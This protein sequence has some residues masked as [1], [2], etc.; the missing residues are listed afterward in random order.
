MYKNLKIK[1]N[2]FD[3]QL[4]IYFALAFLLTFLY[5]YFLINTG[6]V[7]DDAY[8]SQIK[9][10]ILNEGVTILEKYYTTT[11]AWILGAGRAWVFHFYF[12][13]LYYFTQSEVLIKVI[14]LIVISL[15]IFYLGLLFRNL[16]GSFKVGLLA[17][18]TTPIFFQLRMWHDPILAFTFL[19]PLIFLYLIVSF[20]L[21]QKYLDENKTKYLFWSSG[22]H[23]IGLL[24]Y[25]AGYLF[26]I[27]FII[28]ALLKEKNIFKALKISALPVA[29]S[30]LIILISILLKSKINPVFSS[31]YPGAELNLNL[32]A[33][34]NASAIQFVSG[35][36]L[37]YILF[38]KFATLKEIF[39]N[40]LILA[41]GFSGIIFSYV[42]I[43]LKENVN[44]KVFIYIGSPLIIL[45]AILM[46]ISG[47]QKELTE[48]SF[49]Y[50]YIPVYFQ[51]IGFSI[52]SLG[53]I[54]LIKNKFKSIKMQYII[55][56]SFICIFIII[57][58]LHT[59]QNKLVAESTNTFYLYPRI[60]LKD[61]LNSDFSKMINS[62]SIVVREPRYPY[63]NEWFF[64]TT[65]GMPMHI[66]DV[67]FFTNNEK[68]FEIKKIT[69]SV[70]KIIPKDREVWLLAYNGSNYP[71][72]YLY[73]GR[74]KYANV[75]ESNKKTILTVIDK[76][77]LF[78]D[79]KLNEI[80]FSAET[81]IDFFKIIKSQNQYNS[82][83]SNLAEIEKKYSL[84]EVHLDWS[85]I[86]SLDGDD[87]N[88]VRWSSGAGELVI[89]NLSNE[90]KT[91]QLSME[92]GMPMQGNSNVVIQY[93]NSKET[94][95]I[96][97]EKIKYSKVI[98]LPPGET[99]IKFSSDGKQLL[100]GDPRKIVFGIF[101]LTS[102]ILPIK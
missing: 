95:N 53:I 14:N 59:G 6:F 70:L 65:L 71:N 88:N 28:L 76:L 42:I 77:F 12:Y 30:F 11:K 7:S 64:S 34:M 33:A 94:I 84:D 89:H 8:N 32:N 101:N 27:I 36:P 66:S 55:N 100:N 62:K 81:T 50:G 40:S 79:K 17:I 96:Q 82:D 46:G 44:F 54:L 23:L 67:N 31:G 24:T 52:I 13:I 86:H 39:T 75:I 35:I 45:P 56:I 72:G 58:L 18:V 90:M 74:L 38:T 15:N 51:Y 3:V 57:G 5:L 26:F 78:K 10:T 69:S 41:V 68:N 22:F 80:N 61:A 99:S 85:N 4:S 21:F 16:T 83:I 20:Y 49:G 73:A 60:L 29:I 48:A 2:S 43:T 63:D 92:L 9:G 87:K 98:T 25:E 1:I 97:L 91:I 47:H 102:S 37:N 19:M 93:L